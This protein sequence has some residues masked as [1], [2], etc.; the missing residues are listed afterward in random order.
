MTKLIALANVYK[1]ID[2]TLILQKIT[3]H[4]YK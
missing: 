4:I 1:G 2:F 3:N